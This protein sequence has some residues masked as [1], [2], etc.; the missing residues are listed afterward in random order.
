MT[1]HVDDMWVSETASS[2]KLHAWFARRL[3]TWLTV[4]SCPTALGTLCGQLTFRLAWCCEHSV[5]MATEL[6]QP[7]DLA[8]GTLFQSSCV[9]MTSAMDCSDD[10]WRD[11]FSGKHE[12]GA[13]WLLICGAMEK[14]LL[15]YLFTVWKGSG[16]VAAH[17]LHE[18]AMHSQQPHSEWVSE[19]FLNSMSARSTSRLFRATK[20]D[21][22]TTV[23]TR[24]N[25]HPLTVMRKKKKDLHRQQRSALSHQGLL[26]PIKP[27]YNQSRT[28]GRLKL[29]A[30]AFN[31][32]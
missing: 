1:C 3:F 31:Q 13:L 18:A 27:A 30:S 16:N 11:T 28:D 2:S 19:Q 10:S 29:T 6:L 9:I 8:R 17:L 14:H 4:V 5:V 15:T 7:R 32:L 24:R 12:H 23:C 20:S 21:A 26:D 22:G 25:I